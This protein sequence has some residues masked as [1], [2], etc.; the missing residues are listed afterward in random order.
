MPDGSPTARARAG[1]TRPAALV[2]LAAALAGGLL[3]HTTAQASLACDLFGAFDGIPGV[4]HPRLACSGV[5]LR[6]NAG[7]AL[8]AAGSLL[9]FVALLVAAQRG[10]AA[11]RQGHPW[12][13]RRVLTR[14]AAAVERRLPGASGD[15]P[16]IA[17]S[18]V[19]ALLSCFLLAGVVVGHGA[20]NDHQRRSELAHRHQAERV[21]ASLALPAGV[22]RSA[23]DGGC[24]ASTDTLC[25]FSSRS[26]DDLRPDMEALLAGRTSTVLCDLVAQPKEMP[27]PVTVY[28]KI[29]GYPAVANVFRHLLIVRAGDEPP[30]GAVPLHPGARHGPFFLGADINVSL[31]V[32]EAA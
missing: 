8:V 20:W 12:P 5:R 17:A 1:W 27:C 30:A 19:G 3:V 21:L 23:S 31:A 18:A 16:R 14:I 2:G 9:T 4:G 24:T 7:G 6:Y 13:L 22:T 29:A 28:G 26:V 10:R 25:A 11:A 15:S 32:A